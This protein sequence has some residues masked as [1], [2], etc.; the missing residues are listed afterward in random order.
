MQAKIE[1]SQPSA[2]PPNEDPTVFAGQ[3]FQNDHHQPPQE[4]GE[5][6]ISPALPPSSFSELSSWNNRKFVD[7]LMSMGKE[8]PQ[9]STILL[10]LV[11][12]WRS[13]KTLTPC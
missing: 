1:S 3:R 11:T 7:Q 12:V 5:E 4:E 9:S 2:P 8:Q 6:T 10:S 13:S